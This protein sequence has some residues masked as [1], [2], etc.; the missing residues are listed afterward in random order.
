[1]TI[2]RDDSF[3]C[4]DHA[5]THGRDVLPLRLRGE[6]FEQDA[7][8][9]HQ[10]QQQPGKTVSADD[11]LPVDHAGEEHHHDRLGQRDRQRVERPDPLVRRREIV[12]RLVRVIAEPREPPR[13][14]EV[15]ERLHRL[16]QQ[17]AQPD[18]ALGLAL[19]HQAGESRRQPEDQQ[20]DAAGERLEGN[21]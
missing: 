2:E 8:H 21:R 18:A 19:R 7:I 4:C 10:H 17:R 15:L 16:D 14:C 12:D 3:L 9:V 5:R 13:R 20:H 1:M 6:Q 11:D